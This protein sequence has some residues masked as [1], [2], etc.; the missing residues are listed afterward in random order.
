MKKTILLALGVML[1]MA[2]VA[3]SSV[4]ANAKKA[5]T[6]IQSGDLVGSDGNTLSVG[7]DSW[8]YNYQGKLFN[9]KY[10]DAYRDAAWCQPYAD[11]NLAMKWND[12]W[13][14]NQDCD[15]D[16]S[17][18]RHF[19]FDSYIGSGAWLT[20]HMSGVYE[21]DGQT[22]K[23]NYFVKIVAAPADAYVEAGY[24]YAADGVEIG[25]EI[26]G[27][28]AIIQQVEND[29]CLGLHGLQYLSPVRAGLGGW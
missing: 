5:C 16:G 3:F 13:L 25:P 29:P 28:F 14:S 2:L 1:V 22:C 11:D 20:N 19:G 26:W 24:W 15:G 21:D 7:F 10:C 27:Q 4:P 17:L 9:G 6:T 18:D 8:G 12:A 23:W